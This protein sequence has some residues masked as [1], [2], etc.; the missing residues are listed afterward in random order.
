MSSDE[1]IADKSNRRSKSGKRLLLFCISAIF[2]LIIIFS[3]SYYG[4]LP[5][6][7]YENT[8]GNLFGRI[9][10][11]SEDVEKHYSFLTEPI[12]GTVISDENIGVLLTIVDDISGQ[13]ISLTK[14][15]YD[16]E[17][18]LSEIIP[19]SPDTEIM[20][21]DGIVRKSSDAVISEMGA[22]SV[23]MLTGSRIH[24]EIILPH[25][26]L[27]KSLNRFDLPTF[28]PETD[29]FL[30]DALT[31]ERL[32]L[33]AGVSIRDADRILSYMIY[34]MSPDLFYSFSQERAVYI[35][36][37]LESLAEE[38]SENLIRECADTLS[39]TRLIPTPGSDTDKT[40]Y[41]VDFVM[42]FGSEE[43]KIKSSDNVTIALLNGSGVPGAGEAMKD[44]L[45]ARGFPVLE[46]GLNRKIEIE[47][48]IENDFSHTRTV[49]SIVSG[50]DFSKAFAD[51]ISRVLDLE[52]PVGVEEIPY[53]EGDACIVITIG[54]DFIF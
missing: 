19:V 42:A 25:S 35:K 26:L 16:R 37:L 41:L 38:G 7:L 46:W 24:Y 52:P 49:I 50:G 51:N 31:G 34:R 4:M 27:L 18:N 17:N 14:L 22:S 23:A 8:F 6:S 36:R 12:T 11:N 54:K 20:C 5:K 28:I 30:T 1:Q 43:T 45:I 53:Y 15:S 13:P 32:F 33:S 48:L 10:E 44:N 47:G 2:L 9:D 29:M 3:L 39:E 21:E 40:T